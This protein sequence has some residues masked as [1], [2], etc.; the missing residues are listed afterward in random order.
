[1]ITVN[2][3]ELMSAIDMA[4]SV[5]ES[6][7]VIPALG[8][9]KATANGALALEGSDLDSFTRAEI[10]YHGNSEPFC[11]DAPKKVRSAINAA[12]GETVDLKAAERKLTVKAGRLDSALASL[13]ADDHP[14]AEL[15]H[16]ELFGC[17]IGKAELDQ[18]ARIV[19]AISAEV[20]RYYLNG[21]CVTK[22]GE[23]LYRFAATDGHRLM[24]VDVPLP[25]ATGAIPDA[26]IIPRRMLGVMLS[27]FTKAKNGARLSY[28][29]TGASNRKGKT[30]AT[31]SREPRIGMAAQIG[32]VKFSV[33]GKLIDAVY[34]DYMRVVPSTNDK[35]ARF[36]RADM[37]Q[38]VQ[39]I[40]ALT[41]ER[42]RAVKLAF[43]T[44]QIDVSLNSPE[45]GKSRFTINAEHRI[46]DGFEIGFNGQYLLDMMAAFTGDEV[47]MQMAT[48][49]GPTVIIDTA[50][51]AFK[52]VLM[53][54]RV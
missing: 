35:I 31:P 16:D 46:A 25:G 40:S 24:M 2:R 4:G 47:E 10:A 45:V 43:P 50:D 44:G 20:T 52:A 27:R 53:P 15:I 1:M 42:T 48:A 12:G 22:I 23:W 18:I 54:M 36:A 38:A 32:G 33:T 30:L 17:D 34:P 9:L 37:V 41:N 7:N 51:T 11:I 21:V 49:S 5:I 26:T 3:K 28:G 14:G 13:P 19:P 6:R 29:H 8:A 39:S